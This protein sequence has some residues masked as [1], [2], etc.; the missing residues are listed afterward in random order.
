M[1][2][3]EERDK[4]WLK[5]KAK[6]IQTNK[7]SFLLLLLIRNYIKSITMYIIDKEWSRSM[8]INK[9][10]SIDRYPNNNYYFSFKT[11]R[12]FLLLN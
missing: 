4:N 9:V 8:F 7:T 6:R 1:F 10:K 12:Y 11:N 5:V 3:N 2:L